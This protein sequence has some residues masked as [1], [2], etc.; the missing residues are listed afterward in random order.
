M[1]FNRTLRSGPRTLKNYQMKEGRMFVSLHRMACTMSSQYSKQCIQGYPLFI[2]SQLY[3]Y[4]S[5]MH[6][7]K[8]K[9]V[10]CEWFCNLCA[11]LWW[12]FRDSFDLSIFRHMWHL[13]TKV[14]GKW[15]FST[16]FSRL[17]F[18]AMFFPQIE[19]WNPLAP[20]SG[21]I[22]Y[23]CRMFRSSSPESATPDYS[24]LLLFTY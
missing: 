17:C 22:M 14:P 18:S 13:Y 16:W 23:V 6:Y 10:D 7:S 3:Q 4:K 12:L 2:S 21:R 11:D 8:F 5:L 15:M 20:P 24:H 9:E 1:Y 19:H